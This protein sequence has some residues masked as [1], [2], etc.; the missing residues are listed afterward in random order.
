MPALDGHSPAAGTPGGSQQ[1]SQDALRQPGLLPGSPD[2]QRRSSQ[3]SAQP[4]G[5]HSQPLSS[6]PWSSPGGSS[7]PAGLSDIDLTP[8]DSDDEV[9]PGDTV[10]PGAAGGSSTAG[11]PGSGGGG[12]ATQQQQ[13]QQLSHIDLT[14]LDDSD[15]NDVRPG[16]SWVPEVGSG[17]GGG[18]QHEPASQQSVRTAAVNERASGGRPDNTGDAALLDHEGAAT[19]QDRVGQKRR[20]RQPSRIDYVDLT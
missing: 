5:M 13:Q 14:P 2:T 1:H 12:G 17:G 9:C 4:G 18:G 8:V 6:Q 11:Q 3:P 16:D 7:R 20:R 19:P 15:D 10:E